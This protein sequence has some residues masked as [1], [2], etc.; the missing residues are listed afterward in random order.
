MTPF[1]VSDNYVDWAHGPGA[2]DAQPLAVRLV[3]APVHQGK[4][5]LIDDPVLV[6]EIA[7]VAE[8]YVGGRD[9]DLRAAAVLKRANKWLAA[10][11]HEK[12]ALL[13]AAHA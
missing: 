5:K 11:G 1:R 6:A 2:E 4:F 7:D 12:K 9:T 10:G 3:E 8:L 13:K